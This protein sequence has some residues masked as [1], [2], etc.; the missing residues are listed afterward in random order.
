MKN[1]ELV[2]ILD[3]QFGDNHFG[4]MVEKYEGY[5]MANRAKVVHID[6]WGMRRMAYTSASLKKRQQGYYV[7]FQ[8]TAEPV[9]LSELERQLSLDEGVLRYMVVGVRGEFMRV[10]QLIPEGTVF[11]DSSA[12]DAGRYRGSA[13]PDPG[14][15]GTAGEEPRKGKLEAEGE[16]SG[17]QPE[18]EESGG[19]P[20]GEES[21]G[22]PEGTT[23]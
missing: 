13:S 18:G 20:E 23:N 5:L 17:G 16:E 15:G 1:Y 2:C 21:G 6:H 4:T 12:R 14:S 7:L 9:I 19:Q 11:Q 8:F 10:P 22:Q 3:P